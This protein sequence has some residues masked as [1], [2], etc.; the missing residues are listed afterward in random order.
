MTTSRSFAGTPLRPSSGSVE[1]ILARTRRTLACSIR[2]AIRALRAARNT[3]AEPFV[4]TAT[5]LSGD[6][7]RLTGLERPFRTVLLLEDF[8][9]WPF[10]AVRRRAR[11]S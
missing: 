10:P 8:D 1:R 3:R 7:L 4:P 5:D 9:A 6:E 2:L 11:T